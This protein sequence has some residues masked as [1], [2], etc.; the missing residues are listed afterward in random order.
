[1]FIGR[2]VYT[3]V[4]TVKPLSNAVNIQRASLFHVTV[5]NETYREDLC[6]QS[7]MCLVLK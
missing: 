7:H 3:T 2:L 4:T 1:M 6:N 5:V